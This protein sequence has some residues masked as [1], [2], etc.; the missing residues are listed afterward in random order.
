M[1]GVSCDNCKNIEKQ[2]QS[3]PAGGAS[4]LMKI[5]ALR[6]GDMAEPEG[7]GLF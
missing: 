4:L 2:K 6:A 5:V 1:A 3:K 7:A